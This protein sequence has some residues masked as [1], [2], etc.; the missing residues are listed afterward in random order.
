M[1]INNYLNNTV[2]K[3][4]SILRK[5]L[6]F[7]DTK[8]KNCFGILKIIYRNSIERFKFRTFFLQILFIL[9]YI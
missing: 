7:Y 3:R 5:H 4:V 8:N 2:K 9:T 6:K 1:F